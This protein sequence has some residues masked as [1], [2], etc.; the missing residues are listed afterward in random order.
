MSG[1]AHFDIEVDA[2]GA[3]RCEVN[4]VD[5]SKQVSGVAVVAEPGQPT[6]VTLR[7]IGTVEISG[8]GIVQVMP[9]ESEDAVVSFLDQIDAKELERVTFERMGGGLGGGSPIAEAL[10]Q[11]KEWA[12]G[13]R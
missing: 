5:V 8:D 13:E 6:V 4:G 9:A 12:R 3:G 1:F 7:H 10:D 11:L 2:L